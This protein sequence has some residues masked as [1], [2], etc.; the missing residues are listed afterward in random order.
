MKPL[1]GMRIF[2][3]AL[4]VAICVAISQLLKLEYPFYAA[5]AAIISMESSLTL[6]FKV[7][8][9][10][11]LGTLVG[12][13]VGFVF[14][15]IQPEN[16]ILCGI[17]IVIIIFI[18]NKLNWNSS[19]SIAGIVFIAIMVNLE[20]H[21]PLLYGAHRI[22]DTFIG[23][24]VA[25]V[26]NFMIFPHEMDNELYQKHQAVSQK[27]RELVEQT[28]Y[29]R[30]PVN[31]TEFNRNLSQ[32]EQ[33]ITQHSPDYKIR[34][35]HKISLE[36]VLIDLHKYQNISTHLAVLQDMRLGSPLTEENSEK[37]R[38]LFPAL[39]I[40]LPSPPNEFSVVYNYH[41]EQILNALLPIPSLL[42]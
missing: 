34:N 16:A 21:S 14:A 15:S 39:K 38:V 25:L 40:E 20:G 12:A 2:K 37:I 33:Q 41:V 24:G 27:G 13:F 30:Q 18:L 42:A 8:R 35:P 17:G 6:S 26:V 28:L 31:L 4:A 10:R 23:I 19:I 22:L 5:I 11:M 1:I 7:G 9:N 32:L 3:T 36:Q 29:T